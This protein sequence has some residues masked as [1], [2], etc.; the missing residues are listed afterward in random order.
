MLSMP[1]VLFISRKTNFFSIN[2]FFCRLDIFRQ[3]LFEPL[4]D[5]GFFIL[6]QPVSQ[7]PFRFVG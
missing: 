3:G 6:G 5:G 2:R 4:V 1:G 7:H